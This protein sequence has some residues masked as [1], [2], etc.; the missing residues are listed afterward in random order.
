MVADD[1]W[2]DVLGAQRAGL[3]GVLVL[4]GKHGE[5]ELERAAAQRRG[6]GRPTAVAPTVADVVAA[7][8]SQSLPEGTPH[9]E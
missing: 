3:R 1:L 4:T 2:F 9:D 6:G 5:A 7:L 8:D